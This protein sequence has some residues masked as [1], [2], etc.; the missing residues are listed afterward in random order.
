MLLSKTF[1]K[2]NK[3]VYCYRIGREGQSISFESRKKH[4]NDSEHVVF[5][6]INLIQN[7]NAKDA[8]MYLLIKKQIVKTCS[9]SFQYIIA[10]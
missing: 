2:Y 5:K 8:Q 1:A 6:C 9:I 10:F 4:C 7:H 3:P